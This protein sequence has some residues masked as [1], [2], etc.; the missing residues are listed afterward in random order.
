LPALNID[1][2]ELGSRLT[3]AGVAVDT[4]E[5]VENDFV[6]ELDLTPN[7]SDCLSMWGTA[8]E[9][10]AVLGLE[11][12][13][14]DMPML[15]V[16]ED[17]N[18][19]TILAKDKCPQY[20]AMLVDEVKVQPSP[21]WLVDR[22][23]AAGVRA[24]N[25][26]VDISNYVMLE[27][28]QPLHAFDRQRLGGQR[29]I[30]RSAKLGETIVTLDDQV[31]KLDE[32]MLV[33]AD[34]NRPVAV[35]GVMGGKDSEVTE[36]TT[37][38]LFES[39][40]FQGTNVR[41]TGK[42]MG[43]RSEASQRFEKGV[44]PN[45]LLFALQRTAQLLGE[46]GAGRPH[47]ELVGANWSEIQPLRVRLRH[48][49]LVD[50][51][52][53][54]VST[55]DVEN[56]FMRLNFT[57]TR[58]EQEWLVEVP[59]RRQDISIEVDL[60][61]EVARIIGL[62]N[63]EP[64]MPC[65]ITTQGAKTLRQAGTDLIREQLI[66]LG[67]HEIVTFSFISPG[68]LARLCPDDQHPLRFA[69]TIINPLTEAQS[70]MRTSLLPG[71]LN[72]L[73]Y[74]LNRQVADLALFEMGTAFY[75]KQLPMSELPT[76][77][78]HL[79][80]GVTGAEHRSSW[81]RQPQEMDFY[82]VKGILENLASRCGFSIQF[83]AATNAFFHPFRA[84][85]LRVADQVVGSLG[86]LHPDLSDRFGISKRV[87]VA[88]INLSLLLDSVKLN[89]LYQ[90]LPRYPNVTRDMALLVPEELTSEQ[91]L[92]LIRTSGG[93]L[94]ESVS[95]FDVYRGSQVKDGYK[96]LAFSLTYRASDRTLTDQE[97]GQQH[98]GILALVN[99]KLG[100]SLR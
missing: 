7:R 42:K 19:V 47:F 10:A 37:T 44:D 96:S 72:T 84:A 52:G 36:Q 81:Q 70:V 60:I 31:R 5:E 65:G 92:R 64:T 86:E 38:I 22:L 69:A 88:D 15:T 4:V 46:L 3:L 27:T 30:V 67:M 12:K 56:V 23:T 8:R 25:N 35:A 94:L 59:T 93:E 21:Q 24:I 20:L 63:L 48:Q 9:V 2:K 55:Q 99:E 43:L 40:L 71:L 73:A 32:E 54:Q 79:V 26:I 85:E 50:L 100:A 95:L 66:A 34:E 74:N 98:Q 39:A 58:G 29:V 41:R 68:D 83:T 76:E 89:K 97:V 6:L 80:I 53:M 49:R 57:F 51:L 18:I 11:V 87:V 28:G 62:D 77:E 82:Y 75:P 17:P 90:G 91:V 33:I 78:Q 14:P 61:E 16:K 1:P 45:G 13:L